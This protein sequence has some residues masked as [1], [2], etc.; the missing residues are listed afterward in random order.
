MA[1]SM[2]DLIHRHRPHRFPQ[3]LAS[4]MVAMGPLA[5]GLGRGYSSPALAS[6]Q[7]PLPVNHTY[8]HPYHF[9]ITPD[10]GSW[11][12]SLSLLG[13]FFGGIPGG[14]A[15]GYGRRNVL[16]A[17][18]LPFALCWLLTVF[19]SN[20]KMV[21]ASSFLC[22]LFSAVVSL[23]TPV[24]ISE[25]AHPDIRGCLC[26]VAKLAASVGMLLS[27]LLGVYLDWRQL[28]M[29][30]SIAPVLLFLALM[31]VP[32][33][34]SYLLYSRREKEAQSSLLW[35]RGGDD[36]TLELETMRANINEMKNEDET[37]Q[38]SLVTCYR[39]LTTDLAKP[40]LITCGLMVFQKFSGANAFNFYAVPILSEAFVGINPYSA[41]VVV[42]LL[43]ILAG[44]VSSVLIDTAGRLPL[45]IVSNLLM[46]V[47]LAGFGTFLYVNETMSATAGKDWMPLTC[48]L[49]F[50]VAYSLGI[51]PIAWL[52][53]GELF[54]LKHRGLGAIANSV[55]YACSFAS[56]KTFV[57]FQNL[58]GL[59]GAFWL[60]SII[61]LVGLIFTIVIVP[62][63]KGTGLQEMQTK[64]PSP[65]RY[66][67][68][69]EP[70]TQNR[71]LS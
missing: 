48:A 8:K 70:G 46:S 54:P 15:M 14:I 71:M 31:L 51:S 13:A 24:Y 53:I 69:Y 29:V 40:L 62:E 47:A 36:I 44:M 65:E 38:E 57:D 12:A 35:L 66:I 16:I 58:L 27:F 42:G 55:S 50:Q 9:T 3:V 18:S 43:Q 19:A 26:S 20:V 64:G 25:I 4:L 10:E 23:V 21:Y 45:L 7:I 52:Y 32:E 17:V 33:T 56:V 67:P 60:Y 61:A 28:A 6:M 63:T 1:S 30:A 37:F 41:A 11:I 5:T 49:V 22:G 68:I 34:P 2:Q 39:E 59:Y